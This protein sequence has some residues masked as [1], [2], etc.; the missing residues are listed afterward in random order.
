[1]AESLP[2]AESSLGLADE[3]AAKRRLVSARRANEG[4]WEVGMKKFDLSKG[5]WQLELNTCSR[6][7][8]TF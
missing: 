4:T 8:L 6:F 2:V 3:G 7:N 1:M 5:T